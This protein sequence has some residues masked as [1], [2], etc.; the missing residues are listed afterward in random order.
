M[1]LFDGEET[2]HYSANRNMPICGL[3]STSRHFDELYGKDNGGN[4]KDE[5]QQERNN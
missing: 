2:R 5:N 1:L 4:E 3:K